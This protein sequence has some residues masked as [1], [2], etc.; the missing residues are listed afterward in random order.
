LNQSGSQKTQ[1]PFPPRK[2]PWK[3]IVPA[4]VLLLL[5]GGIWGIKGWFNPG[6]RTVA[7]GE[8]PIVPANSDL[9]CPESSLVRK[10]GN[11]Y[12]VIEVGSTGIKSEVIQELDKPNEDGFTLIAREEEI[13]DRNTT[14]IEPKKQAESVNAIKDIIGEIKTRFQVPCEQIIIFGSS[15]LAQAPHKDALAQAIQEETGR[16]ITFI[17]D[18]EEATLVFEG[19]VPEWRRN[20]V[21]MIDIGSG[22]IKGAYLKDTQN[23][24]KAP[25]IT[26]AI[27]LGTKEFT[28][29]I[30]QQQGTS[31]FVTAAETAK[32][33][34]LIPEIREVVRLKPGVQT[35][36][37]V[38]LAGG[39]S[40]ALFTLVRPCQ[41]QQSIETKE[42]RV[43]LYGMI[44][45]DDINTFY[46]NARGDQKTLFEPN[47]SQCT[48]EQREQAQKDIDRLKSGD[49]FSI[50]N[51]IAGAEILRAFSEE[52]HFSQRERIFFARYAK[53]AL[54]IGYLKQQLEEIEN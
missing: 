27:P 30:Q 20:Q 37:R 51:L 13:E 17:S 45:A 48:T 53:D 52:L 44:Y 41:Q 33:N 18:D 11:L 22:N 4:V 1:P 42:E 32:Q 2:N 39:I 12:G 23:N 8:T 34:L 35:L 14:P 49:V 5:G 31:N 47:L 46:N 40:W 54:P 21:V 25:H 28:K 36:P 26:F 38:Y 50:D 29:K 24:K 15:G 9:K 16:A 6:S 3:L 19:V 43:A 10:S 7:N